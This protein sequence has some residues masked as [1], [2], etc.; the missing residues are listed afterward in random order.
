MCGIWGIYKI[1]QHDYD[2]SIINKLNKIQAHRG[3]DES[4]YYQDNNVILSNQRLSIMDPLNGTQPFISDD[5]VVIQNGEIYNYLEL[6]AE[7]KSLGCE[8]K[9]NC[10]TEVILKSYE[11]WGQDFVKKL[12]GMFAIAIFDKRK[13]SLFLYRDRVGVKPLYIYKNDKFIAFASE[14]KTLLPLLDKREVNLEAIHHFLSFNYIPS[15][16]TAFKNINHLEAGTYIE[17]NN[18]KITK[19]I[20]WDLAK[21][22]VN[23]NISLDQASDD[24]LYLLEEATKIRLRSDV[25]V[26]GFLSGGVDSS[27]V[28]GLAAKHYNKKLKTYSIGFEDDRFD[29][30]IYA[31]EA[32]ARFNTNH[33][34]KIVHSDMNKLW[35]LALY[36]CDQPHGDVSFV[37][38]YEVANLA[39][40]DV[41]V[42]LTGD[43][44]DEIFAG[45]DK[46]IDFF[47]KN[48]SLS[49]GYEK[50]YF[51]FSSLLTNNEKLD[52]Y[53]NDLKTKFKDHD[54]FE[55][56][57]GFFDKYR[58]FDPINKVL[59]FDTH[60]LLSGNNL[61]KPDRMGMAC[62][63]EARSPFLDY[64]VIEYGF[65]LPG[66][67]KIHNNTS[68]YILKKAVEN[69]I[70]K[71]LTHRK[72]QMFTV[73]I[74]EWFKGE[75]AD[76]M[77][78][79]LLS[80]RFLSRGIFSPDK[81]QELIS[82]HIAGKKNHT[83]ILRAMIAVE[84][85]YR[86]FIDQN[87]VKLPQ[88]II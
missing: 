41:K 18:Q 33:I 28:I 61:V 87:E 67:F 69:L 17:F 75:L 74:G 21:I 53:S 5:L 68:K 32:A 54:S 42:V 76:F 22:R 36:F 78:G 82:N 25:E 71:N 31:K 43:G 55:F 47:A 66:E 15:P 38:T 19:N 45:Y 60:F 37:P 65:S 48:N 51:E 63:L 9:T 34:S 14:I 30:T 73:P 85:W 16:I 52:I 72:K 56:T 24:I 79:I 49:N 11:I 50:A 81:V 70:G 8:F 83:R 10:D 80:D 59:A 39:S 3:P 44:G 7:L 58:E 29:E 1:D 46:Y 57:R 4:D 20:W 6:K 23:K 13:N 77:K 86:I 84:L 40:K 35:P 12:N 62:S 27:T 88:N 64:R 2:Q 26:A